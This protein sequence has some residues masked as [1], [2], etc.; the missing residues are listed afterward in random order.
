MQSFHFLRKIYLFEL[1]DSSLVDSSAFVNQMTSGGRFT[2]VDMTD[3]D[4]VDM[5]LFF[6]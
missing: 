3:D 4:D 5:S 2:G 6:S 1:F